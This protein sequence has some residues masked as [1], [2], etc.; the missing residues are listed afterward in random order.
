VGEEGGGKGRI[1]SGAMMTRRCKKLA[2]KAAHPLLLHSLLL[3][4]RTRVDNN[5]RGSRQGRRQAPRPSESSPLRARAGEWARDGGGNT[6]IPNRPQSDSRDLFGIS[7]RERYDFAPVPFRDTLREICGRERERE[8]ER[9]SNG[10]R[11][12]RRKTGSQT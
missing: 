3:L 8:R 11:E 5:A 4:P 12:E 1:K 10:E 9:E 6:E 2:D 7:K